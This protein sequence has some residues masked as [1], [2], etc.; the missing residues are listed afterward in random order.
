MVGKRIF[1]NKII[2]KPSYDERKGLVIIG[3]NSLRPYINKKV[4]IIIYKDG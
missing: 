2:V 1:K 3:S 4:R